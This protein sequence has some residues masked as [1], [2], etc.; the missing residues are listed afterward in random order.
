MRI[1]SAGCSNGQEPYSIA[2]TILSLHAGRAPSYDVRILATDIDPNVVADGRA[3]VYSTSEAWTPIPA[4]L[5][6]ALL[7]EAAPTAAGCGRPTRLRELV[8]FRELNLIGD[9]PMKGTFDA[10]FCRNVVIYFDEPT[11]EQDLEPLRA[12]AARP[13]AASTSAIP[14]ASAAR[15]SAAQTAA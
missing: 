6:Q 13:A 4:D 12:A 1:W 10:I 2:L 3:G 14:S 11:Q 5:R 8:S 9:W 15:P 7:R